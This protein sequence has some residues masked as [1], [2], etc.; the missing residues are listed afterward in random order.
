[1]SR[2]VDV[3]IFL[4]RMQADGF[5]FNNRMYGYNVNNRRLVVWTLLAELL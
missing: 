2:M 3:R 1:M 4:H 5:D